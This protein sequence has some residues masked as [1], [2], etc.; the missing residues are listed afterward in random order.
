MWPVLF[1][2]PILNR[3]VPAFGLMMTIGFLLAIWWAVRRGMRSGAN[4]DVILNI[5]F[6]ALFGGVLGCRLM[7]VVHNWEDQFAT[8]PDLGQR[9]WAVIDLTKG[10]ME[11]YGGFVLTVLAVLTYL[12]FWK[13]SIRWY[14]DIVA[15]SVALGMAIGRIG[16]FLNGCCWGAPCDLPWGVRFPYASNPSLSQWERR[17][18]G[19]ELPQELIHV[20]A[21][22]FNIGGLLRQQ[23]LAASDR[24]ILAAVERARAL[25][26]AIHDEQSSAGAGGSTRIAQLKMELERVPYDDIR[27]QM[28]RYGLTIG[29]LRRLIHEH[30]SLPVHPTQLYSTAGLLVLALLLHKL[31]YRRKRDGQVILTL[32]LIEP[33]SRF[34]IEMIRADNPHD[35]FGLTISQFIALALTAIGLLGLLYTR[36]L[37]ARSP[38]AVLWEPEPEEKPAL[39]S[40]R[41]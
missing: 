21:R 2:L 38:R 36:T 16:C 15:P 25:Q 8:I 6:I 7:Y 29:E 26:S 28:D 17:L 12:H 32:L 23:N 40:A 18:P 35:T 30:P 9:I 14:L 22:N 1:K 24:E 13:H 19:A 39:R 5:G 10:G 27:A 4:P 31:Y 37:P 3:E 41:A 34:L 20:H 33:V 11:Y